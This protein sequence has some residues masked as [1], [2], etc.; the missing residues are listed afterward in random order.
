MQNVTTGWKET[1]NTHVTVPQGELPFAQLLQLAKHD[2]VHAQGI[3][4]TTSAPPVPQQ[5]YTTFRVSDNEEFLAWKNANTFAQPHEGWHGVYVYLTEETIDPERLR[6][7]VSIAGKY[8]A[9][10]ACVTSGTRLLLRHVH[11]NALP[12][13]YRELNAHGWTSA[14][15]YT[16]TSPLLTEAQ[17]AL[18]AAEENLAA[19]RCIH[20]TYNA[21]HAFLL[22]AKALFIA[23]SIETPAPHILINDFDRYFRIDRFF[24]VSF[25]GLVV[26]IST[27][28]PDPSFAAKYIR[29]ARAFVDIAPQLAKQTDTHTLPTTEVH[30]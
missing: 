4:L 3:S 19:A 12:A 11:N 1:G 17:N 28:K 7:F 8:V 9:D 5:A 23:R 26:Q 14:R 29:D 20:A 6:T 24:P 21:Y 2:R 27:N 10:E 18:Q 13:L 30:P 15:I 16:F 25:R 22:A